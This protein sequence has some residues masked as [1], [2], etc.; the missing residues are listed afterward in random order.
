M[1][2]TR[3]EFDRQ[4]KDTPP[5]LTNTSSNTAGGVMRF[6]A[7]STAW[8]TSSVAMMHA[9][10]SQTLESAKSCPGQTLKRTSRF[11]GPRHHNFGDSLDNVPP[12]EPKYDVPRIQRFQGLWVHFHE[13]L[14]TECVRS[15]IDVVVVVHRP[16]PARMMRRAQSGS[17]GLS[18][19]MFAIIIA[20]A[21][22]S[23][24]RYWSGTIVLCGSPDSE[25]LRPIYQARRL[26]DYQGVLVN[27]I[28]KA[29]SAISAY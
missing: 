22:M 26:H 5:Y 13:T 28:C 17:L 20:S 23:K 25:A 19:Q 14:R 11:S 1:P 27:S 6:P 15:R 7:A 10:A 9:A 29:I 12:A 21:G 3:R 18:Y 16:G 4:R 8:L 24:P 2:T